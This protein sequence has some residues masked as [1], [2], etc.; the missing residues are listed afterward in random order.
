MR[1]QAETVWLPPAASRDRANDGLLE[2]VDDV[3]YVIADHK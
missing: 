1:T 3:H 2:L